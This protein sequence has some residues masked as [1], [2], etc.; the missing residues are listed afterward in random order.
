MD[1]N[2]YDSEG[3]DHSGSSTGGYKL[4]LEFTIPP[5]IRMERERDVAR[6][7]RSGVKR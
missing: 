1:S 3:S 6:L 5:I 7:E 4:N 2:G